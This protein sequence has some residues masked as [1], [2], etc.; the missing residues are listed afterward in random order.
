MALKE[1]RDFLVERGQFLV[2]TPNPEIILASRREPTLKRILN[3][4]DLSIADGTG[5]LW[6]AT[7]QRFAWKK[8]LR[9]VVGLYA[10]F[11]YLSLF[12]Y[13]GF[14]RRVLPERV[15]GVDLMLKMAEKLEVRMFLLGAEEGV[16]EKVREKLTGLNP[17][18]N[19]VGTY[20]GSPLPR[21]EKA[22]ITEI[23]AVQPEILLVAFGAPAQ[24]LWLKRNLRKLPS[25]KVAMGV[26]GSFDF[27]AGVKKRAPQWMRKL[28]LEWLFR[29]IM[30]PKRIARIYRAVVKFPLI[31][32]KKGL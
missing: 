12:F 18:L 31:F 27:I 17:K 11:A 21:D 28:G 32:L 24:E 5:I 1:V 8:R 4:A 2:V 25:V 16:A 10:I 9:V 23:K 29:L 30:Q 6:A 22:I 13:P 14:C 26:G 20:S 3:S 15:T 19:V 7:V